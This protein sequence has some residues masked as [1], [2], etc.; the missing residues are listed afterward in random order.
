MN[1]FRDILK[2]ILVLA[3]IYPIFI[4]VFAIIEFFNSNGL[5]EEQAANASKPMFKAFFEVI[6]S[7]PL[8]IGCIILSVI[9]IISLRKN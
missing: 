2:P 9:I 6:Y 1:S 8:F 3:L 4:I 7:L 5:M